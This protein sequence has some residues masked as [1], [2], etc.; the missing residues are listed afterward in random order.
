M[1][2]VSRLVH[3]F[4]SVIKNFEQKRTPSSTVTNLCNKAKKTLKNCRVTETKVSNL[5]DEMNGIVRKPFVVDFDILED[6]TD[7]LPKP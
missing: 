1:E 7:F 6:L 2:F 4:F 3:H 5:Y